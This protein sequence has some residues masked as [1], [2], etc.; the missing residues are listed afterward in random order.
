MSPWR[1]ERQ[2]QG[3][4]MSANVIIHVWL[5]IPIDYRALATS[6]PVITGRDHAT[7]G[8]DTGGADD[9]AQRARADDFSRARNFGNQILIVALLISGRRAFSSSP[10]RTTYLMFH[11]V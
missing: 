9:A 7:A 6:K 4:G 10:L 5:F 11:L 1:A 2:D 8:S 3:G